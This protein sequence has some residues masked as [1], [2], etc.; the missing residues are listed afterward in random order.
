MKGEVGEVVSV[1]VVRFL[2]F[3]VVLS[4]C[5]FT[6][7]IDVVFKSGDGGGCGVVIKFCFTC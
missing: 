4:Y 1:V 2:V 6:L 7:D 5:H 3:V